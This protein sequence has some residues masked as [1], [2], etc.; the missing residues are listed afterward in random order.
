MVVYRHRFK[1]DKPYR[2]SKGESP[3]WRQ[4]DIVIYEPGDELDITV[5]VEVIFFTSFYIRPGKGQTT[6]ASKKFFIELKVNFNDDNL[7]DKEDIIRHAAARMAK[8]LLS[9]A[10]LISDRTTPRIK[11]VESSNFMEDTDI[12]LNKFDIEGQCPTCGHEPDAA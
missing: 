1:L 3:T 10:M 12:D 11:M 9:T 8:G 5:Q 2:G 6:M 4:T 7:K